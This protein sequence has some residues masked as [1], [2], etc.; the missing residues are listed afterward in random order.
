MGQHQNRGF[1]SANIGRQYAPEMNRG[2]CAYALYSSHHSCD[3]KAARKNSNGGECEAW[4]CWDRARR[5]SRWLGSSTLTGAVRGDGR[6]RRGTSGAEAQVVYRAVAWG[7]KTPRLPPQA[8]DFE[9]WARLCR[10]HECSI[11]VGVLYVRAEARTLHLIIGVCGTTEIVPFQGRS[12]IGLYS[13]HRPCDPRAAWENSND[14]GCVLWL[15]CGGAWLRVT[16]LELAG[17]VRGLKPS[18][19]SVGSRVSKIG[20]DFVAYTKVLFLVG[21]FMYGLKPVP[22]I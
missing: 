1:R 11:F 19:P 6:R 16:G 20:R 8:R 22:F 10:V 4:R 9:L 14:G 5:P 7:L 17:F 21:L 2:R 15:C 12:A 3:P 18:R 13:D